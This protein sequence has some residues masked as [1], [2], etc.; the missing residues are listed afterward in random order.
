MSLTGLLQKALSVQIIRYALAGS[1]AVAVM[2]S[3]L[4][5]LVEGAG[6]PELW[7][8]PASLFIAIII[9]YALQYHFTFRSKLGHSGAFAKFVAVAGLTMTLN[10]TLFAFLLQHAHYLVAQ[11][12]T[13]G[14]VFIVN[15]SVN[16]HFTFKA[17]SAA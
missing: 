5:A 7:A 12:V 11:A 13:L 14:V 8:S 16:R 10:T 3:V 4:I 6:A 15:Y 2:F 9:N 1:F 17:S